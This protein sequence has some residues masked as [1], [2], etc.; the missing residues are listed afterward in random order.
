MG[1]KSSNEELVHTLFESQALLRPEAVAVVHGKQRLTYA[2]LNNKANLV[3]RRLQ[4]QGVGPDQLVGLCVE[5]G[6]EMV[7]SLLGIL[8]AGGAYL[9][10]D[11]SY[12][13]ERLEYMV[14]DAGPCVLITQERLQSLLSS[15]GASEQE[16]GNVE[17]RSIGLTSQHLA[18]VI[19]T[20]GSTGNPKGVMVAHRGVV[21]LLLSMRQ[22][23][24]F[25]AA[26]RLLAITTL[27]FDIAGLELY[28]PLI[29][30]GCV[31]LADRT[32][33]M[34]PTRLAALIES[35][36]VTALQATPATWRMLLDSGWGGLRSLKALCGGEALPT[37][38]A[39]EL[40][41]RV[42]SLWNVYGPTETTI[43][44]TAH[45]VDTAGAEA[46]VQPIGLP[47]ANT[48]VYL[49]DEDRQIVPG[50]EMGEIYVGGD[51]VARGYLN[52]PELTAERFTPNPFNTN[53]AS[54]LYKTGD[55]GRRRQDGALEYLGRS[56]HQ[57]K[58]RGYR[59]EL[60]EI[61]AQ[62]LRNPRLKE[63][64]V[65]AREDSPGDL[66]LVAYVVPSRGG[67]SEQLVADLRESLRLTL[68]EYM[69]PS[70]FVVLKSLPLTLNGKVDRRALPA[71]EPGVS[72]F[73]QYE[74]PQGEME[75]LLAGVWQELLRVER[76]G[77][78]DNF[79][80]LGGHSLLAVKLTVKIAEQ[81]CV[82][83]PV[84][85]VFRSSTLQ[86]LARSLERL[87][88]G[89]HW[90]A[91]KSVDAPL[92]PRT[93]GCPIPTTT[94]QRRFWGW[95]KEDVRFR[96]R[97]L[98]D[99]T[100]VVGALD[101]DL[102]RRSLEAVVARHESLRTRIVPIEGVPWQQVDELARPTP[103]EVIDLTE[104][105]PLAAEAQVGRLAEAFV[106]E[107]IDYF[108]GPLFA[109]KLFR[110]SEHDHVLILA[111]NHLVSDAVSNEVLRG[112]LWTLY[113]QGSRGM[114]FSLP[115]LVVQFPDYATWQ[116]GM[117]EVWQKTHAAYWQERFAG[118][119]RVE[120]PRDE[121]LS[122]EGPAGAVFKFSLGDALSVQLRE[123]ARREHCLLALVVF[124]LHVTVMS[125]W[126]SQKDLIAR[127]IVNGRDR[128]ELE[129]MIG[130]LANHLYL[131]VTVDP[132]ESFLGLL[133]RVHEEF[134]SA[135]EHLD[136]DRVPDFVRECG[137][138]ELS[139]NWLPAP[140][141]LEE[142]V[143]AAPSMRPRLALR[144]FE[145][146]P[147]RV[148]EFMPFFWDGSDG[149]AGS[150]EY[151]T[152][153]FSRDTMEWFA[154]ELR[155]VAANVSRAESLRCQA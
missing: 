60:G 148:L 31:V 54:R 62:L 111:S 53:S 52:R 63:A 4:E 124:S 134:Y 34:E 27:A 23:T 78:Q 138:T 20:S 133:K 66:R 5:R 82:H 29:C 136:S 120:L 102:L 76:V 44:S 26:D 2:E 24:R 89:K 72:S 128:A 7:V 81:F 77:R 98:I 126:C 37:Q 151:R 142:P 99:S 80:E 108:K 100:R 15:G 121:G 39:T 16:V 147:A 105:A 153:R 12:P 110:V 9:P 40:Q 140:Q 86:A 91:S 143:E 101:V 33:V 84:Q 130:F 71:P 154:A 10:L 30:G 70:E 56:D 43:W 47:I 14:R 67:A 96:L 119:A 131:R 122:Q 17:P 116:Q 28:L 97:T 25:S 51:G 59:I 36:R 139:F 113:R 48:V 74:A 13:S 49:L 155:R 57:V 106:A 68:P 95:S 152:G 85:A 6:V 135:Y 18:Y 61:E 87:R 125:R 137:A 73:R 132:E 21:N 129:N 58:L 107:E 150:V 94:M 112:E 127:L 65:L 46:A 69:V 141:A 103:L 90:S 11:P 64:V 55:L 145:V 41:T 45:R 114:P 1:A 88:F 35:Q 123:L 117:D 79:L 22:M 83:L 32:A 38:L 92:H 50:G 144:P 104:F 42:G 146:K 19:Y 115:S 93:P 109:A 75:E 3:A 118:A 149:I 8:K